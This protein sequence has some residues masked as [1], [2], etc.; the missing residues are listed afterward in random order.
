LDHLNIFLKRKDTLE[1]KIKEEYKVEMLDKQ[2]E[3]QRVKVDIP[4]KPKRIYD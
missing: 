2:E 3:V 4:K 1:S